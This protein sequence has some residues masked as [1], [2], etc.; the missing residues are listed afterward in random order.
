MSKNPLNYANRIQIYIFFDKCP[1]SIPR[2][3]NE[4]LRMQDR[5][6]N[7]PRPLRVDNEGDNW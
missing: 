3:L 5:K 1:I 6:R 2:K 7:P 4:A